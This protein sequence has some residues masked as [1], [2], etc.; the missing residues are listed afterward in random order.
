[1]E[2]DYLINIASAMYI[3][4][5]IPELYANYKNKNANIY[6]LPEKILMLLGTGFSLTYAVLN[7]NEALITNYGPLFAL[8]LVAFFTRL[9]YVLN[10]CCVKVPTTTSVMIQTDH[11]PITVTVVSLD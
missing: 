7:K 8:D 1:M 3:I 4:C 10:N 6:N 11:K 9:H 2:N 5:Y